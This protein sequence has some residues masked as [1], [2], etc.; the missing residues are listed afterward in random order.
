V[1]SA[2]RLIVPR[3]I[4]GGTMPIKQ[5]IASARELGRAICSVVASSAPDGKLSLVLRKAKISRAYFADLEAGKSE[6][7]LNTIVAFA[8]ALEMPISKLIAKTVEWYTP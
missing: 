7:Y 6:M 4:V 3:V 5:D 8:R 2:L 1:Q